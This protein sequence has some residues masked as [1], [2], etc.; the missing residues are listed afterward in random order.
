MVLPLLL[1]LVLLLLPLLWSLLLSLL[2]L[3]LLLLLLSLLLLQIGLSNYSNEEVLH[4]IKLCT[5]KG[6]TRPVVYQGLYNPLNRRIETELLP[7]LR[8]H[9]MHFVAYNPLAGGFLTG[10]HT[11]LSEVAPGRFKD[12]SNYLERFWK[13]DHFK[14]LE[15]LQRACNEAGLSLVQ[16]HAP[17]P[18]T[19]RC[20]LAD[21]S[22]ILCRPFAGPLPTLG[23]T[24]MQ[25]P[26]GA[27]AAG[28]SCGGCCIHMDI[29]CTTCATVWLRVCQV[30]RCMQ[31]HGW[32]SI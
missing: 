16:V 8:Q 12:N 15:L 14:A 25:L 27:Q 9:D 2:L 10:K 5:E 32:G 6:L 24:P 3:L 22:P 4:C 20:P 19:P 29:E 31:S 21:L 17:C 7:T 1:L 26:V 28:G 30:H 11:S 13:E 23:W 18:D